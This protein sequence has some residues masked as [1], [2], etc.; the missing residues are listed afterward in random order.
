MPCGDIFFDRDINEDSKSSSIHEITVSTLRPD[1]NPDYTH[2]FQLTND[3]FRVKFDLLM[4]N[5]LVY[6]LM[7]QEGL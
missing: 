5:P 6:T 4:S 2:I 7:V 1:R 3:S